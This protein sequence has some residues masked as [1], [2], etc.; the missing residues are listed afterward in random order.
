MKQTGKALIV[1]VG[2]NIFN[3]PV[4]AE[5]K[6]AAPSPQSGEASTEIGGGEEQIKRLKQRQ[7]YLLKMHD[8]MHEI[9][10]AKTEDERE[11]LKL[12]HLKL[13]QTRMSPH[14]PDMMQ[15]HIQKLMEQGTEM[16]DRGNK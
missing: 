3:L 13:L 9:R 14:D 16:K 1:F 12:E 15:E 7:E 10:D 4:L 5:G 8:L 2:L 11:R 6:K